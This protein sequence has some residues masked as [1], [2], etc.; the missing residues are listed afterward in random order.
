MTTISASVLGADLLN[1]GGEIRRAEGLGVTWL[2]LDQMDGH[3]APNISFG[4][5]FVAATRRMTEMFLD[6]HL[7]LSHPLAYVD[8]YADAGADLIVVHAEAEDDPETT[9]RAIRARGVR[10][11]ISIKPDTP[12]EA[13]EALLPLCD[14]VLVMTV[15]PGFGG[16]EMMDSCLE[17]LPVLR[18]MIGRTGRNILLEVDGG[19]KRENA[20]KAVAAGADVL[21]IGTGLFRA[22][23]PADVVRAVSAL[24]RA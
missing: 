3:F 15:E 16:Q 7:M 1:L 8:A 12:P 6:V 22:E 4:P 5:G 19:I 23:N 10:S 17:K 14:L 24:E 9:L 20:E 2:H 18:R 11:G 21:V 13:I